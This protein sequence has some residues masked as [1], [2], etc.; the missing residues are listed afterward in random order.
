MQTEAR[1]GCIAKENH[2]HQ[3]QIHEWEAYI[4]CLLVVCGDPLGNPLH[5]PPI[6]LGYEQVS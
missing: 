3:F 6:E 4:L 2:I 5:V 1:F